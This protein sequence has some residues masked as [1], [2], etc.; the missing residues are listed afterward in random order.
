MILLEEAWS[1]LFLLCAIQWSLPLESCP[2]LSVSELAPTLNG[3]LMS[4]GIDVRALQE[5]IARF[6]ALAVDPTEFACM[7]AIILFKP[8]ELVGRKWG[9]WL[10]EELI[11]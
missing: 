7:K 5:I 10:H 6:K 9:I 4:A 3:K 11:Y 8:G 2:L 1:E